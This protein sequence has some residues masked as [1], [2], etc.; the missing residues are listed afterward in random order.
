[1]RTNRILLWLSLLLNA[2]CFL[3]VLIPVLILA[4]DGTK[5]Y[6]GYGVYILVYYTVDS[7]LLAG[8]ASLVSAIAGF[9]RLSDPDRPLPR[10]VGVF[11]LSAAA[12]VGL[13]FLTI[14]VWLGPPAGYVGA[15]SNV[16]LYLHLIVPLLSIL[17]YVFLDRHEPIPFR[18]IFFT[19]LPTAL[20]GAVYLTNVVFVRHWKDFYNLYA[21]G[22]W[23]LSAIVMLSV[24][25][26][27]GVLLWGAHRLFF[28]RISRGTRAR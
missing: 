4:F 15:F 10:A 21:G 12:S 1:M 2:V 16:S 20:Y 24:S 6:G 18:A 25:F 22:F 19:A 27:L 8:A 23:I 26:G 17:S 28:A 5:E 14:M 3:L 9:R 11:K 7:N 13:T